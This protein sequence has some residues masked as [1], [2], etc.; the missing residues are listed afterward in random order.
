MNLISRYCCFALS[1]IGVVSGDLLAAPLKLTVVKHDQ[2]RRYVVVEKQVAASR[3][4]APFKLTDDSGK[5]IPCQWEASGDGQ[6]VRF[7]VQDVAAG[8]APTFTLDHSD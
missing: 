6:I 4:A 8:Q 7:V 1:V 2:D 3:L 5:S